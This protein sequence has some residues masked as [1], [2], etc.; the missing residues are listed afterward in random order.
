MK[1]ENFNTQ[2]ELANPERSNRFSLRP[3]DVAP[4]YLE[5]PRLIDLCEM[6]SD[7]FFE[8]R[9][10]ALI[11]IDLN[12]LKHRMNMY[13]DPQVNWETLKS[14]GSGLTENAAGYE[15]EKVRPKVLKSERF[16]VENIRRYAVRP[17][18]TR[19]CY[20][21]GI[22]PLWNR[23]R[24]NLWQQ[25]WRGNRFLVSRLKSE[26]ST[27][28]SPM[29]FT[30]TLVG[31]QI[32]S[33]NPKAIPLQLRSPLF[34]KT[35][36]AEQ[37]EGLFDNTE[38]SEN[39]FLANLTS[40]A[41]TYLAFMN[42]DDPDTD[43]YNSELIW[44]HSLAIGY[45]PT[46][47][48]ENADGLHKDWPRI[49]LPAS[50]D[51]LMKSAD[52]GQKVAMLLD[53][54]SP[55]HGIISGKIRPELRTI[56]IIWRVGGGMVNPD[57]GDLDVTAGW[58]HAGKDGITMP[59]KGKIVERDYTSEELTALQEGV[60]VLGL[61]MEEAI[62]RLG[63]TTCDIYLNNT[64]YWKNVPTKVWYYTIGGY[65]I[66]KK[67]L[68]YREYE[69][70]GRALAVEEAREVM[71]MVRRI[72]AILL[73]ES[74]LDENYLAIKSSAYEWPSQESDDSEDEQ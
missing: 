70:L 67:W 54:E 59:G 40:E 66:I 57:I 23:S 44:M 24:P 3:T 74:T 1:I 28:G 18:D 11:D 37:Q 12:A 2:Y 49:P 50:K 56:A 61:T 22:S 68:S 45:S 72:A 43:V 5:W 10:G 42:I 32:I 17:F 29:Y 55:V 41:R 6:K 9:G 39:G 4:H 46:Y 33:V 64:V 73:L 35:K 63:N 65:Q 14:L 36:G 48:N 26:K 58:G 60:V 21:S 27:K 19:W 25:C 8:K 47:L 62:E 15:A 7:G 52:L 30:S 51:L 69:F 31:G 71:S 20:Y 34:E 16:E 13:Y 53:T 38:L